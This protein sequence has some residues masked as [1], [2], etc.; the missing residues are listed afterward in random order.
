MPG[1]ALSADSAAISRLW[2]YLKERFPPVAYS[3]LVAF[4]YGS[5]TLVVAALNQAEPVFRWQAPVVM[6]LLF[7]HLRVFDEHKDAEDDLGAHPDRL[8]SRGVVTLGFLRKCAGVAILAQAGLA[9]SLGQEALIAWAAAFVFTLLMLA[10]FGV[11]AWLNRSMLVYAISHNP[12]TPLL[13]VFAWASTG[14]PWNA[15]FGWYLASAA[16]GAFGFEVGR[17]CRLPEEEQEGVSTYSKAYGRKKA[18]L[19]LVLS[20]LLC[21]GLAVPVID[22]IAQREAV[23]YAL[24]LPA[25]AWALA[26]GLR[27]VPSK[28]AEGST[29]VLLLIVFVVFG[30]VAW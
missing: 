24:L 27:N 11:G 8:L 7:F 3:L 30:V 18:G 28:V 29:T 6:L 5:A 22:A 21:V 20:A 25:G 2:G 17:K 13:G 23:A 4:F 16:L 15:L 10:E 1:T 19:I 9:A 12:I 14:L 26:S